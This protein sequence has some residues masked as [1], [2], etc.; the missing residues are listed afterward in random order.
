MLYQS[1][2]EERSTQRKRSRT[3]RNARVALEAV[4]GL[5]TVK[6]EVDWLKKSWTCHLRRRGRALDNVFV[7]QLWRTVKDEEVYVKD[8]AT[9]RE[10]RQ[11]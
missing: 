10:A 2:R 4:K 3:E 11:G 5:Q 6:V 9:P 1:P 7:E 8:S